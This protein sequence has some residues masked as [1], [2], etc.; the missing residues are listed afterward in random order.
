MCWNTC[1]RFNK[2]WQCSR[3]Q[4]AGRGKKKKSKKWRSVKSPSEV[5]V[6]WL[7]SF[8]EPSPHTF[9]ASNNSL[10][11]NIII[12]IINLWQSGIHAHL[13]QWSARCAEVRKLEENEL[14]E[15]RFFHFP[16][17]QAGATLW[18]LSRGECV[19]MCAVIS[20][21]MQSSGLACLYDCGLF[22]APSRVAIREHQ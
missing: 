1:G 9:P 5:L 22:T 12:I 19:K 16:F 6:G 10:F 17:V 7:K 8:A 20:V 3:C 21:F 14:P 2:W 15:A 13:T 4:V 11:V 18:R